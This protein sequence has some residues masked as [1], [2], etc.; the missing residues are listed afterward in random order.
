MIVL[1]PAASVEMV[2]DA[3]PP[4]RGA[5][6][7]VVVPRRKVINSPSGGVPPAD[8][9]LAVNVTAWPTNE[10]FSEEVIVV[11]VENFATTDWLN[12]DEVLAVL[13]AS[14]PYCTVIER[15]PVVEKEV[16]RFA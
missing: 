8:V 13:L 4:A 3:E 6:P 16:V 12:A 15:A 10:G 14:P 11:V 9:T 7:S 2:S 5:V 1:V